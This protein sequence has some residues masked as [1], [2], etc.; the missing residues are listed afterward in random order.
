LRIGFDRNPPR[1]PL[2]RSCG[3]VPMRWKAYL[4]ADSLDWIF[5]KLGLT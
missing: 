4:L 2:T 5:F 3:S 1:I